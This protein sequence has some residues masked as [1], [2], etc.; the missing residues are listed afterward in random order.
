LAEPVRG[1]FNCGTPLRS[2]A[3]FCAHCGAHNAPAGTA[4]SAGRVILIIVLALLAIPA[5][6]LGGCATCIGMGLL[7]STTP[8]LGGMGIAGALAAGVAAFFAILYGMFRL[9]R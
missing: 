3:G 1:C 7:S 8:I 9:M 5:A 2:S 4:P 6:A